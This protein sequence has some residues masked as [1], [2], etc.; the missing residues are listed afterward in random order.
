MQT[1]PRSW[2][3][4]R[5]RLSEG[6]A[7]TALTRLVVRALL[8][9]LLDLLRIRLEL[10][11]SIRLKLLVGID[12]RDC[13]GGHPGGRADRLVIGAG[14]GGLRRSGRRLRIFLDDWGRGPPV[15]RRAVD[16]LAV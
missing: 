12:G 11:A 4:E 1:E 16:E 2:T 5:E 7:S 8:A 9:D 14:E 15:E 6:E 3:F 13:N 10:L